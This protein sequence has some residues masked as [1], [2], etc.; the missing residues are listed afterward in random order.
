MSDLDRRLHRL[1]RSPLPVRAP[2]I[3][4]AIS[5]ASDDER[6]RLISEL[7]EGVSARRA[8]HAE[9]AR[10]ALLTTWP[11]LSAPQ[12]HTV[13]L[14]IAES[15]PQLLAQ[16]VR[17][18]DR[19]AST[20][21][22]WADL[23]APDA[24]AFPIEPL[25]HRSIAHPAALLDLVDAAATHLAA[26]S[27]QLPRAARAAIATLAA[28]YP[29][30]TAVGLDPH[31]EVLRNS[32]D[33]TLAHLA[34]TYDDHR[35][36]AVLEAALLQSASPGPAIRAWL[37]RRDDVGHM[38]LRRV[39]KLLRPAARAQYTTAWLGRPALAGLAQ[40]AL[41]AT[42]KVAWE[43]ALAHW[44]LLIDS[45]RARKLAKLRR[46]GEGMLNPAHW[47]A[48]PEAAQRGAVAWT[49]LA[50]MREHDRRVRL[51]WHLG[52]SSARARH[53]AVRALAQRPA[54]AELDAAIIDFTHD[55]DARVADA[56][57]AALGRARGA[58]RRRAL[59][60]AI[61]TAQR[62]AH[63]RVRTRARRLRPCFDAFAWP[64][65]A[66]ARWHAP[67]AARLLM[68]KEPEQFHVELQVRL[69]E[70]GSETR[71]SALWLIQH[72]DL[73]NDF[74][75]DL[76]AVALGVADR[77]S[78]QER[79][80][81][82]LLLGAVTGDQAERAASALAHGLSD[83]DGR[84]RADAVE[85][86]GRLC[87]R[88]A[89]VRAFMHDDIPRVRGNA[90][91]HAVLVK[92]RPDAIDELRAMLRDQRMPHRR[93]ALWVVERARPLAL[94]GLIAELAQRE[95]EPVLRARAVRCV[96]RLLSTMDREL[97]A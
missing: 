70:S 72:L 4:A 52:A 51:S 85:A 81:A 61:A 65:S 53:A 95:P 41:G 18:T 79:A 39:A 97:A 23:L 69:N 2:A 21:Q 16:G 77:V 6:D 74:V 54:S 78:V 24:E 59:T 15:L 13:L 48:L 40:T 50:H 11:A 35:D 67:V 9:A 73:A 46:L 94:S 49:A 30:R 96:R 34:Q 3:A 55:A 47:R 17:R 93:T 71:R 43:I 29:S 37:A 36:D 7:L 12:R 91:R 45:E 76:I 28:A 62:S 26:D 84:I 60:S 8:P 19:A 5:A 88:D 22:A 66:S 44:P 10:A 20:L 63:P 1:R 27:E 82:M 57:L 33:A 42:G 31:A 75:D 32:V 56:A 89:A 90:I 25:V 68:A 58:G 14:A 64:A 86:V 83:A 80:K 38:A 87:G 92:A